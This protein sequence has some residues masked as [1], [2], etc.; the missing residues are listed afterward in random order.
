MQ[1]V[2]TML[3][4]IEVLIGGSISLLIIIASARLI[5]ARK[6]GKKVDIKPVGVFEDLPSSVT[7][8]NKYDVIVEETEDEE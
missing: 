4:Y 2:E 6:K 7:G 3:G 8:M 1:I 5:I